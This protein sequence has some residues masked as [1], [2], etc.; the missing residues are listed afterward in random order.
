M[1]RFGLRFFIYFIS[2]CELHS[3]TIFTINSIKKQS[4]FSDKSLTKQDSL[5]LKTIP[6]SNDSKKII[7][8]KDSSK[9]DSTKKYKTKKF[10]LGF[11]TGIEQTAFQFDITNLN[12]TA[13][14]LKNANANSFTGFTLGLSGI[15]RL[16]KYW[17]LV[18]E[19]DLNFRSGEL[20]TDTL[21]NAI[22]I[23]KFKLTEF[24]VPVHIKYTMRQL[25]FP[26]NIALGLDFGWKFS[27][28]T[29]NQTLQ[30][31]PFNSY[32]DVIFGFEFKWWRFTINPGLNYAVG[33]SSLIRPGSVF[34][35]TLNSLREN[36]IG[37][38]F[39]VF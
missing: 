37:I 11:S 1:I 24:R 12:G 23:A 8:P 19:G 39:H 17:D 35:N 9:P 27:G 7:A 29:Q 2:I 18:G 32:V 20:N 15:Y 21:P 22:G 30:F 31:N 10:Q 34:D 6:L 14:K 16:S 26:P 38:N 25:R 33:L 13:Q 3:Q 5:S 28:T 36:R 4:P